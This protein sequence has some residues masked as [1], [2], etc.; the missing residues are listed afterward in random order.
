MVG[1]ERI[2]ADVLIIGGGSAGAMAA[3]RAK[4]L[5]PGAR[6]VIFEKGQIKYSGSIPRG[7]DALNIV[8]VPGV[9]S[10]EDY[11]EAARMA[12]G[13]VVDETNSYVMAQRSWGLLQKLEKWGV[14]FVRDKEGQYEVLKV[15]PKG[16]FAVT[17]RA[18]D[19]KVMLSSRLLEL[20]CTVFNRTMAVDLLVQDGIVAGA[21]GMNV[22]TGE[23]IICEAKAVILAAGGVARF[24]LPENGY[25]YGIFDCPANTGD[26]YTL[27]YRAGAQLTGLEYTMCSYIVKDINAPLLYITLT[28][29]AQLLNALGDRIDQGHPSTMSMMGEHR[30]GRSPMF[31]R[32]NHLSNEQIEAVEDILFTTE[33]PVLK[34]FFAGRGIDFRYKDIELGPTEFFLCG[35]HGITGIAVDERAA[36]SVPGL[37]AAGDASNVARGH[38]TGAFV[39]GEIAAESAVGQGSR[40]VDC[41]VEAAVRSF[42]QKVERW[43]NSRGFVGVDEFEYKVRRMINSYVV[44]PKN[45]TK[46]RRARECM[47]FLRRE[48]ADM[49]RIRNVQDVVKALEV[50][51]IMT[52]AV[53]SAT[54]SLERKES[55]WGHWH[56]R[57]DYPNMDGSWQKHVMVRRGD[58]EEE[59]IALPKPVQKIS[60]TI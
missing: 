20:G 5:N 47:A 50:E 30:E 28:R 36:S 18:P 3:I 27:A 56:Y 55:R 10:P 14:H 12:C 40:A 4:E 11:V 31:I 16:R 53:L 43:H 52:C 37:Y 34:R 38:L 46:L 26:A 1:T 51:N 45:E 19:L 57:T 23:L 9:N 49:V 24:G 48:L 8:A 33:R 60:K 2:K 25:L 21:L 13:G 59:V 6:V 17:M 15:H 32:M 54:A 7:M 35:G 22:R 39:F 29:G 44:P 42:R 41:D 58:S